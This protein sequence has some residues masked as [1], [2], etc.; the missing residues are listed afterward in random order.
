M[1][2]GRPSFFSSQTTHT[3]ST[4]RVFHKKYSSY[5]I[6][7]YFLSPTLCVE[8]PCAPRTNIIDTDNMCFHFTHAVL[9]Q[10]RLRRWTTAMHA[11]PCSRRWSTA[12][13]A[14]LR[15]RPLAV[16][17]RGRVCLSFIAALTLTVT[18]VGQ[19]AVSKC[20]PFAFSF[21]TLA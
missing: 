6:V 1:L 11:Q 14:C 12:A 17:V 2:I 15:T 21:L 7:E 18:A 3:M 13:V 10:G 16:S 4:R 9:W 19:G 20:V 8:V 5:E